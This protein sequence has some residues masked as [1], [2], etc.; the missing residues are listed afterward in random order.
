MTSETE[1]LAQLTS[2]AIRLLNREL[3]PEKTARFINQF[4]SGFGDYTAERDEMIGQLTV[5][6]IVAKIKKKRQSEIEH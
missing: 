6:E 5:K 4:T 1:T 3:G 2:A